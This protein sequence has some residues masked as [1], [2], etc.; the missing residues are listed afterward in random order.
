[1]SLYRKKPV[2]IEAV[3]W[4][5]NG[6]HSEDYKERPD[7]KE[8]DWEGTV[9]RRFRHPGIPGSSHCRK[10]TLEIHIHG[11]IDTLEGG[12]IVCPGDWIIKGIKGEFYPCKDD[13]FQKTYEKVDVEDAQYKDL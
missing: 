13:I 5:R 10:C 2:I 6:D 7:A 4:F 12:H 8:K 11:W 1:M 3:Q 9:V